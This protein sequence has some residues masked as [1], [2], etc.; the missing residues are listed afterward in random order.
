MLRIGVTGGIGSGKSTV[1]RIFEQAGI[2]VFSADACAHALSDNDADV[3]KQIRKLLG[4]KAYKTDGT[5]DRPFVADE[6][7]SNPEKLKK[8]NRIVHPRVIKAVEEFG[9]GLTGVP[10]WIVEAALLYESGLQ[11][12]LD[13]VIGVVAGGELRAR[14]VMERDG[15]EESAVR[16]RMQR[17]LDD[18]ALRAKV[19]FVL[20]N[21]GPAEQLN[22]RIAFF[23]TLFSKI[24][25]KSA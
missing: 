15:M 19:D 20:M 18:D 16:K 25:P 3:R 13:Y 23:K 24:P 11:K 10:F 9:S 5:L 1:C 6:V 8:L 2:P 14:R 12:K 21:D 22:E 17:Q 4:D 7:F